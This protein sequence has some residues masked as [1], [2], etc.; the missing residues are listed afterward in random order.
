MIK[1][2]SRYLKKYT[3]RMLA[4]IFCTLVFTFATMALPTLSK[5]V[6]DKGAIQQI[7]GV[8]GKYAIIMLIDVAICAAAGVLSNF[9]SSGVVMSAIRDMRNALFARIV[10]FSQEDEGKI[11]ASSLI[12]RQSKDIQTLQMAMIQML[13]MMLQAPLMCIAGIVLALTTSKDLSWVIVILLPLAAIVMMTVIK[14]AR[15]IFRANQIKVDKVNGVMREALTGMRVIRAFNREEYENDRFAAVSDD[16]TSNAKKGYKM[17]NTF[18]PLIMF[19]SNMSNLLILGFG[20]DYMK[21]GIATYGAVQAYIQYTTMILMSFML[22]S[23]FLM[24]LP[25]AQTAAERINEIWDV[26]PSIKDKDETVKLPEIGNGSIEVEH[27]SYRFPGASQNVLTDISFSA[28]AGQTVAII[29]GT[30]SGKTTLLNMLCRNMD[31]TEGSVKIDGVDIRDTDAKDLRDHISIVPQKSFLFSGSIVDNVRFGKPD[32]SD[33]EVRH[34]LDVS[35]ATEFVDEKEYGMYTYIA[36]GGSNVSGGQKQRLAI[37]RALVRKA[38]IYIFDDSFSALD[39][40]TDAKLRKEL[41]GE[42]TGAVTIIVAQ[43]VSTIKNADRI[44]VIEEGKVV[45]DGTHD[46]L[47]AS[48]KVY[49]EIALSQLSESEVKGA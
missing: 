21:R 44:L 45:G 4:A 36:Q 13:L 12:S 27:V 31:V 5:S 7:D 28:K 38:D 32:A 19:F 47:L 11:G 15:P 1:L 41:A 17:M 18:L 20:A 24:M 14:L 26:E 37:A 6:I 33:E 23:M 22:A 43:R 48:N 8:I 39:F 25:N 40:K 35:Q 46:E 29:G 2:Y 16:F 3:G 34:A 9:F 42:L 10:H 30:G 49:R